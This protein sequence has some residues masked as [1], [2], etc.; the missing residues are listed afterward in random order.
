MRL[1]V[2]SGVQ[3]QNVQGVTAEGGIVNETE[4]GIVHWDLKVMMAQVEAMEDV[5][6]EAEVHRVGECRRMCNTSHPHFHLDRTSS[7]DGVDEGHPS[8][9]GIVWAAVI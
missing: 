5:K 4:T 1:E 3:V 8:V 7:K 2:A 9:L 6:V